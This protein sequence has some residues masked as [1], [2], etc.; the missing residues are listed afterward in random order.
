MSTL[1]S[2]YS[3]APDTTAIAIALAGLVASTGLTGGQESTLVDNTGNKFLGAK[4]TGQIMTGTGPTAGGLICIYAYEILK[5]VAGVASLPIAGGTALT[6]VDAAAS[7]DVEQR[8]QLGLMQVIPVNSTSNRAYPVSFGLEP[9]FDGWMPM[10]WGLWITHSTGVAL[11]A[12]ATNHWLH[13][14]GMRLDF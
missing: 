2:N 6:G 8:N 1:V 11:N 10:K 7:F 13:F 14:A 3:A 12:T 5:V 9:Q 4:V